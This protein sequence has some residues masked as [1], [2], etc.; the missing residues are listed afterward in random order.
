MANCGMGCTAAGKPGYSSQPNFGPLP[1]NRGTHHP[2]IPARPLPGSRTPA[3]QSIMAMVGNGQAP[4]DS[5][6]LRVLLPFAKTLQM[7]RC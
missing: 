7:T 6:R 3:R 5:S 1:E 2:G 4:T